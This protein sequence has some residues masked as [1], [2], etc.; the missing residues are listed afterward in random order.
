MRDI[1]KDYKLSDDKAF[2]V[3]EEVK[4]SKS[5]VSASGYDS[6]ADNFDD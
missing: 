4:S 5:S 2:A 6:N 3:G 1:R